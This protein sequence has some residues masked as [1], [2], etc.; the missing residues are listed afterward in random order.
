MKPRLLIIQNRFVI[1]GQALDTIPLAYYLQ[2]DF[3]IKIL[4]GSKEPDEK[5][6]WFLLQKYKGLSLQLVSSLQRSIHPVKD[7]LAYR[8]LRKHIRQFKPQIVHTHGAKSGL[9][10][11][12][13]AKHSK[14]P[15]IVHTFHGHLF[16]SYFS[17]FFTRRLIGAERWLAKFT[18]KI[19][20][21]SNVQKQELQ[22]I[23]KIDE[24]K[25]AIISL[26]IDYLS[27]PNSSQYRTAFRAKYKLSDET[28]AVG[29]LGR[30]VP[31][32]NVGFFLEVVQY[33][34]L[35]HSAIPLKYFLIGDG[36]D[37]QKAIDFLI[38]N[39]ISFSIHSAEDAVVILTSWI[40][41]VQ[42][43]L[44][45][46]DIVALTSF[47]EGTPMSLIEAQMCGKPVVSV[48]AG[49]VCDTMMAGETGF[50]IARHDVKLFADAIIQL[51]SDAELRKKMGAAGKAFIQSKFSKEKEIESFKH[52]Y[53]SLL[54]EK[55]S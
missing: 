17:T 7:I 3:E 24:E 35:H 18:T 14:V 16:H 41:N 42:E 8:Q 53:H 11:R 20:A 39:Q 28:I 21:L 54:K 38:K 25:F 15:V 40:E 19:I 22:R 43:S 49:G 13:A 5:E 50:L 44:E 9:I 4:Y 32:K 29:M 1:G 52:L 31:I 47:N 23:L 26:G 2:N 45:G 10:G 36:S 51:A 12:I 48:N 55:L 30:I 33:L 46:L 34:Q 6:P 27:E 37:K